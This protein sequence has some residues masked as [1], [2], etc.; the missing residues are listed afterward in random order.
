MLSVSLR[1]QIKSKRIEINELKPFI[2][3]NVIIT[4]S[5]EQNELEKLKKYSDFFNLAGKVSIDEDSINLL[6][7]KSTI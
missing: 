4:I 3:K 1:R 5:E 7:E 2:G 6:R